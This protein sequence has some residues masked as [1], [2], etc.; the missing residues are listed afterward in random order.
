MTFG[1]TL[2]LGDSYSTFEGHIAEGYDAWFDKERLKKGET[3]V[4]KV[5]QTWWYPLF[6]GINDILI[7]NES[8]S[9]T[10]VCNTVRPEHT[11]DVS[12]VN[13]FNKLVDEGFFEKNAID[14]ILV[15]GGTNDSWTD[16]PVGK[17]Q[18]DNFSADDLFCV[19]PA[20]GYLAKRISEVVP[21][22]RVCW[23]INTE[24][25]EEIVYSIIKTASN[26]NQEY[27]RFENIDKTFCHPNINGMKQI[28]NVVNAYF[29]KN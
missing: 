20:F 3:N 26:F 14:T 15:F 25:K 21:N 8:Y 13:R 11:V 18:F 12:F 10:T 5:E 17:L 29:S 2:I 28:R 9:G 16:C 23:L 1:K 24:L 6:D 27:I 19:L 22:A 4:S 7:Y